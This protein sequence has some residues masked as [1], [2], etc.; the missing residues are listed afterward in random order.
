MT[1]VPLPA[2][3][4]GW[5]GL[6]PFLYAVGLLYLTPGRLPTFGLAASSP[7]GGL[8]MLERLGAVV[9][10]FMGGCLWAF[11]SSPIRGSSWISWLKKS[12]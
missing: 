4:I 2:L 3:V 9:L 8:Y 10:A 11:A 6:L 1:R 5:L 7:E 12:R